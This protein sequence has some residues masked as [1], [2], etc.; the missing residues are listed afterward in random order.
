MFCPNCKYEFREGFTECNRCKVDL[1]KELVPLDDDSESL[2]NQTVQNESSSFMAE[3]LEQLEARFMVKIS[4]FTLSEYQNIMKI[5]MNAVIP[6]LSKAE[7]ISF[8]FAGGYQEY[9]IYVSTD[10]LRQTIGLL[11]EYFG[12]NKHESEPFSGECPACG[13]LVTKEFVCPDCELSLFANPNRLD[14]EHPFVEFLTER[15][16]L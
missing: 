12:L 8:G 3:K 1:V 11:K 7:T 10:D 4:R 6:F 13:T 16:L 15:G 5:L 9:H 2:L 14:D